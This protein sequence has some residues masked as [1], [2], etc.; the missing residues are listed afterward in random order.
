M[1]S[2][3]DDAK[4]KFPTGNIAR[5]H[6][7][8]EAS[9]S[10]LARYERTLG[11]VID[12][13][14]LNL[15]DTRRRNR[16]LGRGDG[17]S[18]AARGWRGQHSRRLPT[19]PRSSPSSSLRYAN[20]G[21]TD[22][23]AA[24]LPE[25]DKEA[26]QWLA[27]LRDAIRNTTDSDQF[28][29]LARA[30]EA[31][32][33]QLKE[34][35]A[36]G[37]LVAL[38]EAIGTT[39][40]S[41]RL[42][43]LAHAYASVAPKAKDTNPED[44]VTMLHELI[45][46]TRGIFSLNA[47][48]LAY[49]AV[50]PKL[51]DADPRVE[52][53]LAALRGGIGSTGGVYSLDLAKAYVVVA[54]NLND[55][56]AA[57]ELAALREA[58]GKTDETTNAYRLKALSH[59][60]AAVAHKLNGSDAARELAAL[61]EAIGKS[62][63][64]SKLGALAQAYA[65][66]TPERK[67]ASAADVLA[68]LRDAIKRGG[69]TFESSTLLQAYAAVVPKLKDADPHAAAVLVTLREAIGKTTDSESL[70]AL[71]RSYEAMVRQLKDGDSDVASE[72]V[73]LQEGI[74]KSTHYYSREAFA[75]LYATA[76]PKL[77]RKGADPDAE[78]LL[79]LLR[80]RVDRGEVSFP[81]PFLE[82][83]Y[84]VMAQLKHA[85]PAEELAVLRDAMGRATKRGQLQGIVEYYK[86]MA[87]QLKDDD[88]RAAIELVAL[89]EEINTITSSDVIGGNGELSELFSEKVT[90]VSR[91][92]ALTQAY[93]V[94]A[95]KMNGTDRRAADVLTAL[96]VALER[97]KHFTEFYTITKAIAA[98]AP[99]LNDAD[100][101]A[102]GELVALREAISKTTD[103]YK[104]GALARAYAAVAT[105]TRVRS[106]PEQD[107]AVL[108][109][110]MPAL[111]SSDECLAFTEALKSATR[112]GQPR[113]SWDKIGLIYAAALLQPVSAGKPTQQLVKDYEEIIRQRPDAPRLS[114][115]WSGDVW[116][117]AV[118][119]RDHLPGFDPHEPRV[120]FLPAVTLTGGG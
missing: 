31:V 7:H 1:Q 51:K 62:T 114:Q 9:A 26:V 89:R 20:G 37:E 43:A 69:D 15:A 11:A 34:A 108:L 57:R 95:P 38:R 79:T 13:T 85:H 24:S 22:T 45:S 5:A 47:I 2:G 6:Q 103:S 58:I 33:R 118:W 67:D 14:L 82:Q 10:S 111:R 97:A 17:E 71:A 102:E 68:L 18:E 56:K 109:G 28:E 86:T 90:G 106:A 112:L 73:A 36:E 113:L 19:R 84:L 77:K 59:A 80:D 83:S 107:F 72:L 65:A 48:A 88:P 99:V 94:V 16:R 117:F 29:P 78:R 76:A 41:L 53:V 60:Y 119:A 98:V 3:P 46:K 81:F 52:K 74:G 75:H 96:R 105:V 100:P 23:I 4:A 12:V 27:L 35:D 42:E 93:A 21:S 25:K 115:G 8:A 66:V 92:G 63:N 44:V 110:K 54:P 101:R 61:Y 39:T 30:Y 32:A 91:L 120:G 116:A 70:E 104:L 50:A 55:A 49:A 40:D 87:D 64:N